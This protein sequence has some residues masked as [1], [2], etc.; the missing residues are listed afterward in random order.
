MEDA[1]GHD[2][3]DF[4]KSGACRIPLDQY[5]GRKKAALLATHLERG[6]VLHTINVI[7]PVGDDTV[8]LG[9]EQHGLGFLVNGDTD[10]RPAAFRDS[11][12]IGTFPPLPL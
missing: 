2:V 1:F 7:G 9:P 5:E 12:R 6:P 3:V 11:N 8:H 10:L 4:L